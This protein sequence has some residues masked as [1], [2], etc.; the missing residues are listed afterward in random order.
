MRNPEIKNCRSISFLYILYA[1]DFFVFFLQVIVNLLFMYKYSLQVTLYSEFNG[2]LNLYFICSSLI[3][4][5]FSADFV[6]AFIYLFIWFI[7]VFY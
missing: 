2:L 5:V 1:I 3:L 7:L 4:T 6:L